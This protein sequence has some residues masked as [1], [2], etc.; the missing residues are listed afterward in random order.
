[1]SVT[2]NEKGDFILA[3]DNAI[4]KTYCKQL[5][6]EKLH[7]NQHKYFYSAGLPELT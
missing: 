1:M 4:D 7:V 2:Y 6:E 5:H 3:N